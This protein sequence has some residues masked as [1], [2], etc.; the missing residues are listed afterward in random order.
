VAMLPEY[1]EEQTRVSKWSMIRAERKGYSVPS[2]LIG[3]TVRI[4]V[5]L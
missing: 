3:Q 1:V 5:L 2:R 4:H